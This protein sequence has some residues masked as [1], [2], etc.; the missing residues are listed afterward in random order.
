VG[1]KRLGSLA[2]SI[3]VHKHIAHV[4][5]GLQAKGAATAHK[6]NKKQQPPVLLSSEQTAKHSGDDDGAV[7]IWNGMCY[8]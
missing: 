1:R 8:S 2:R 7:I 5:L 3:Q 4:A 6:N